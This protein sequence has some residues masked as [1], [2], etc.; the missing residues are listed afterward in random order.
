M[1]ECVK[2]IL[3][4]STNHMASILIKKHVLVFHGHRSDPENQELQKYKNRFKR[5]QQNQLPSFSRDLKL[6]FHMNQNQSPNSQEMPDQ[7]KAIYIRQTIKV[8]QHEYSLF[9]DTGCCDMIHNMQQSNQVEKKH[10][11]NSLDLQH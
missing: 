9:Y 1:I 6:P 7:E 4:V 10:L 11:N 8:E 2:E 3:C 5:K